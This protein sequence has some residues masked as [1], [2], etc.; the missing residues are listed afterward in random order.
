MVVRSSGS[1]AM[2][3]GQSRR[4]DLKQGRKAGSERRCWPDDGAGDRAAE[5]IWPW[6]RVLNIASQLKP[7]MRQAAAPGRC[8]PWR[9][10]A[11]QGRESND[12]GHTRHLAGGGR[13]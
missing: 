1:S 6:L 2:R 4:E 5:T 9:Y 13:Q 11:A 12:D 3:C 8:D 7:S 10:A